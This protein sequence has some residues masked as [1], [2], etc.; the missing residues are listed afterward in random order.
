MDNRFF[1]IVY[2]KFF[3]RYKLP[4][5]LFPQRFH[6]SL[7]VNTIVFYVFCPHSSRG[8]L[9]CILSNV[10]AYLNLSWLRYVFQENQAQHDVLVFGSIHVGAEFVG[11]GP[12][13]AFEGI[14]LFGFG[15]S[16]VCDYLPVNGYLLSR[17]R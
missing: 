10:E 1:R 4:G 15:H 11:G 3:A 13:R 6:F 8:K 7:K 17:Q 12:E 16:I 14:V 9:V 2:S 5:Q